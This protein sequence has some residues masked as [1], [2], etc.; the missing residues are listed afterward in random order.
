MTWTTNH[1]KATGRGWSVSQ[2]WHHA[3]PVGHVRWQPAIVG[4][5]FDI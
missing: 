3:T 4:Y 2:S 1:N 5:T